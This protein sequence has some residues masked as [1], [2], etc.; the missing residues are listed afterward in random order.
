MQKRILP[1]FSSDCCITVWCKQGCIQVSSGKSTIQRHTRDEQ[2][3]SVGRPSGLVLTWPQAVRHDSS[4]CF[5]SNLAINSEKSN[6]SFFHH[7]LLLYL[8]SAIHLTSHLD[9]PTLLQQCNLFL[10]SLPSVNSL[11]CIWA[12]SLSTVNLDQIPPAT[13]PAP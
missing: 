11:V 12:I 9:T 3:G 4:A 7:K 5:Q 13:N 10:I 8:L 6:C 1:S 2:E